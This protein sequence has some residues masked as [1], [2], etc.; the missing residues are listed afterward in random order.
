MRHEDLAPPP[1][2]QEGLQEARE[3]G[4]GAWAVT[5]WPTRRRRQEEERNGALGRALGEAQATLRRRQQAGATDFVQ[6]MA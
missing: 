1:Q 6:L 3:S 2:A 4:P 5:S